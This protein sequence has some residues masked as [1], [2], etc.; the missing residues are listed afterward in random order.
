MYF[1]LSKTYEPGE[2]ACPPGSEFLDTS[3]T[4]TEPGDI[5]NLKIFV[6]DDQDTFRSLQVN[7]Q[8]PKDSVGECQGVVGC[9]H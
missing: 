2:H 8:V 1:R 5:N 9:M 3:G 4:I 7:E 6:T